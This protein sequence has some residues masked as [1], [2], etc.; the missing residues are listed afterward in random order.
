MTGAL[1]VPTPLTL[2]RTHAVR[3][4]PQGLE[5]PP[6]PPRSP[7]TES[8][9]ECPTWV[10]LLMST[11]RELACT[12]AD[13]NANVAP[14]VVVAAPTTRHVAA[15]LAASSIR[16]PFDGEAQLPE[17]GSQV[18]TVLS[19]KFTDAKA[20]YLKTQIILDGI[21]FNPTRIPPY[22]SLPEGWEYER[23]VKPVPEA[24]LP[25]GRV[26]DGEAPGEWTF[27]RYCLHPVVVICQ[28]SSELIAD[29]EDLAA[30]PHWWNPIQQLALIE[31]IAGLDTWFRRPLIVTSPAALTASPWVAAL[32]VH[33]VVVVG[34]A[35]WTR[36]VR[37]L[38]SGRPHVLVLNQR[39]SD[40]ADF[41]TWFDGTR[42]PEIPL[43]R[44]RNVR[45]AG[46]TVS[47]FGE[48]VKTP[49]EA[50]RSEEAG[51]D[52]WEF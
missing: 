23:P 27:L 10:R 1:P 20:H 48:P 2:R 35:A 33:M 37:H 21:K 42:F 34:F 39:S 22:A 30:V 11:S 15:A 31:P 41:R 16:A 47:A 49:G 3:V 32:P 7:L 52:D 6:R 43:Q 50:N 26:V 13:S 44:L 28:R 51:D 5:T 29:L 8:T 9:T 45:K 36:P 19:R 38:W 40:V 4:V 18:A 17:S 14:R 25:A 12:N 46:L 24:A